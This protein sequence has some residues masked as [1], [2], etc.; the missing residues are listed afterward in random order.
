[1]DPN[2][3]EDDGTEAPLD[4]A[5]DSSDDE[6]G[7]EGKATG[8]APGSLMSLKIRRRV[9]ASQNRA[10]AALKAESSK[11]GPAPVAPPPL[12]ADPRDTSPM[13]GESLSGSD[14]IS[15]VTRRALSAR[16][17]RSAAPAPQAP[18]TQQQ[19]IA[20]APRVPHPLASDPLGG[21]L[22]P[23]KSASAPKSNDIV[24]YWTHMRGVRRFPKSSELDAR[25]VAEN[26]PNSI[27]I[28]CR[29]GSRALEPDKM[30]MAGDGIS[31]G[32]SGLGSGSRVNMS[33]LMLQWLLSLAGEVVR[34]GRPM[35]DVETFP[36]VNR[37]VHYRA[38]ALPFSNDEVNVDHVLCHFKPE[39]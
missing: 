24:A 7:D 12:T 19:P 9:T 30:F 25:Q 39:S 31:T 3:F 20:R 14:R 33:P 13:S 21:A 23:A 11:P 32:L 16:A 1:M 8:G 15:R 38:V 2:E 18:R 35:N 22:E 10:A 17:A 5:D 28:R 29:P 34:E 4:E 26:W 37:V 6:L 27:L 36:S